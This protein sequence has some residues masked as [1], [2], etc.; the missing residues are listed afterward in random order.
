M[1]YSN[2][3]TIGVKQNSINLSN[4]NKISTLGMDKK[5]FLRVRY[6]FESVAVTA[7]Y[8]AMLAIFPAASL[9][10]FIIFKEV[11]TIGLIGALLCVIIKNLYFMKGSGLYTILMI[12]PIINLLFFSLVLAIKYSQKKSSVKYKR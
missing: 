4:I 3:N 6:L 11:I 5:S 8:L 7:L 10:G 9:T 1:F 12:L 2:T